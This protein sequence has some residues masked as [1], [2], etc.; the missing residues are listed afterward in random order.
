MDCS[1]IIVNFNVKDFL[2][3][4][5]YTID[6]SLAYAAAR[7]PGFASE[8][9]VVDNASDDGS[10]D[11]VR[12][13]FPHVV[14]IE[15]KN[16]LGFARANNLALEKSS[17]RFILLINPDTIV[18]EDT[19][20]S[21]M[22]SMETNPSIGM[23]GCK[24]LNPDGTLQLACR[25]SFPRPWVALTKITGLS[26]LFPH[27]RLFG[28]Y[29]LTYLDPESSYE[30]DAISGS[31]MMLKREIYERVGGLD[32]TFFMYG[33]DLDWCYRIQQAGWKIYYIPDTKIIHYKGES[34]RR[35][36]IDAIRT[37]YQ[38][39]TVFVDKHISRS[40][41]VKTFLT[42]TIWIRA[43]LAWTGRRLRTYSPAVIDFMVLNIALVAGEFLWLGR[44][45]HFP[46]YAYPTILIIPALLLVSVIG[47]TGGYTHH[48]LSISRAAGAVLVTFVLLSA[49]TFF[50]KDYAFSRM[51]VLITAVLSLLMIPGW[52]IVVRMINRIPVI[53]GTVR[54]FSRRTLI[55]GVNDATAAVVKKLRKRVLDTYQIFGVID[56]TRQRVGEDLDGIPI[57]GSLANIGKIIRDERISDVIF[58][59]GAL[60]YSE[61]LTV[62]ARSND[63]SVNY[64]LI[65][66]NMEVVI[67]KG[68][69]DQLDEIPLID[70][71]YRINQ[72]VNRFVKRSLDILLAF[73][74]IVLL[75]P[76]I[77][78]L[79]TIRG[80]RVAEW[81]KALP[82]ILSGKMS[83][84]GPP[85]TTIANGTIYLGK[86]GL[87][88][89]VQLQRGNELQQDDIQ[90][91]NLYY[92]KNQSL[93]MDVEILLK[94]F[95]L[96]ISGKN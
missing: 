12:K 15:N 26:A 57:I 50:F 92:A 1:V 87:T 30:V 25:R 43:M 85:E 81:V 79:D 45:F 55:I 96:Q 86:P 5:L 67:G 35:S 66:T 84:V 83:F 32:E 44:I 63:R 23:A 94:S 56:I 4:A 49:I 16:N 93:F 90:N 82:K 11:M 36:D 3:Q 8:I 89:L 60:D 78:A 54:F 39:M 29:N 28:Q 59:P 19:I 17:G 37:F 24:I 48:R 91:F 74:L 76:V 34:T 31:F 22:R 73:V 38:A 40:K 7:C 27:S 61:I 13:K 64:R 77:F 10:I 2:E 75:F 53:G 69:I 20:D 88:G 71:E 72:P 6:K 68:T 9:F 70:I 51:V 65:P 21:M 95:I 47:L 52:R 62:I 33:E 46:S 14:C 58:V 80:K 18:Q 42:L 41:T